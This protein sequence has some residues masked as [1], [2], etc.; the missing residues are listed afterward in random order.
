MYV[1]L[2]PKTPNTTYEISNTRHS[3]M[4]LAGIQLLN[5]WIPA[6]NMPG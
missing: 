4:F 5:I 6:K 3:G 1:W 2:M